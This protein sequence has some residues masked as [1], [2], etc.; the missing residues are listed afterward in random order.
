MRTSEDAHKKEDAHKDLLED[1]PGAFTSQATPAPSR[2]MC[3]HLKLCRGMFTHLDT[4]AATILLRPPTASGWVTAMKTTM[5]TWHR[6]ASPWHI[7]PRRVQPFLPE[8]PSQP[9]PVSSHSLPPDQA[10]FA[11]FEYRPTQNRHNASRTQ[12]P[13]RR[14]ALSIEF[15]TNLTWR[16][17]IGLYGPY[18]QSPPSLASLFPGS[19]NWAMPD[20]PKHSGPSGATHSIALPQAPIKLA[21][22]SAVSHSQ[23][24]RERPIRGDVIVGTPGV[25][26]TVGN[27]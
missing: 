20:G 16:V 11:V 2:R 6:R 19:P 13:L 25:A 22:Q 12:T 23:D 21:T 14:M 15:E 4:D 24:V 3:S 7:S 8:A 10:I 1:S 5:T 9:N 26:R 17:A 18:P 27:S